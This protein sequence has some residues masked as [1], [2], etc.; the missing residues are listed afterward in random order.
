MKTPKKTM[1]QLVAAQPE[2]EQSITMEQI[3]HEQA[4]TRVEMQSQ[5]NDIPLDPRAYRDG[6]LGG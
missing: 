6:Y 3:L 4:K 5:N 2:H 1:A